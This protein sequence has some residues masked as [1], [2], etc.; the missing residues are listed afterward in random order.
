[1]EEE[2]EQL[3]QHHARLSL[4]TYRGFRLDHVE[5][6]LFQHWEVSTQI[7]PLRYWII[8][9]ETFKILGTRYSESP[10]S[11]IDNKVVSSAVYSPWPGLIFQGVNLIRIEMNFSSFLQKFKNPKSAAILNLRPVLPS[12]RQFSFS[13]AE[14]RDP[15]QINPDRTNFFQLS[16]SNHENNFRHNYPFDGELAKFGAATDLKAPRGIFC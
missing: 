15:N 12:E 9:F 13:M 4:K 1:M 5:D 6:F 11:K 2:R 3:E 16:I 10:A 14:L 7:S 8:D